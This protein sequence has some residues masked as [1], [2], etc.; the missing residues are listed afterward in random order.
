MYS[1]VDAPNLRTS[2]SAKKITGHKRSLTESHDTD[3]NIENKHEKTDHNVINLSKSPEKESIQVCCSHLLIKHKES[4]RPQSW[5]NK[6]INIT[7]E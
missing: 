5:K 4:R 2:I 6:N 7:K 1:R 3:A